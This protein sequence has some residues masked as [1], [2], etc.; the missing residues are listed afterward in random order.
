[1][2]RGMNKNALLVSG[3][4]A[5]CVV[6]YITFLLLPLTPEK[7]FRRILM[8]PIPQSVR[9]IEERHVIALDH[10]FWV[11]HFEIATLDLKNLLDSD[12][13]DIVFVADFR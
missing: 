3:V 8:K 9:N 1:M 5:A 12:S 13:A 2:Y 11:L 7:V 10:A 6:A 4:A